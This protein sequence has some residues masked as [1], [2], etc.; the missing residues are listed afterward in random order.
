VLQG[1]FICAQGEDEVVAMVNNIKI[2]SIIP[3]QPKAT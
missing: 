3:D 2:N 1:T